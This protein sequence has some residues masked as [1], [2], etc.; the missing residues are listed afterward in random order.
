MELIIYCASCK[1]RGHGFENRDVSGIQHCTK[2]DRKGETLCITR[3]H[4]GW[5]S[6]EGK[7]I[8]CGT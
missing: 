7:S 6:E 5:E 2:Y 3:N 1:H 8:S 4:Q